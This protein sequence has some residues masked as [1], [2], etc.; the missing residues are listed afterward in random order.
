MIQ[1][2]SFNSN[3][4]IKAPSL[5]FS[6]RPFW[7]Q[8][9]LAH[10]WIVIIVLSRNRLHLTSLVSTHHLLTTHVTHWLLHHLLMLLHLLNHIIIWRAL[11]ILK[12]LVSICNIIIIWILG[13]S[14]INTRMLVALHMRLVMLLVRLEMRV[15]ILSW[16]TLSIALCR[17]LR[18]ILVAL[19]SLWRVKVIWVHLLLIVVVLLLL[20]HKLRR[21]RKLLLLTRLIVWIL[22]VLHHLCLL[23]RH[24][25]GVLLLQMLLMWLH[26]INLFVILILLI[27]RFNIDLILC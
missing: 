11:I 17:H 10:I 25:L 9:I 16:M 19:Q 5:L 8:P 21:K 20:P 23:L 3:I 4:Q 27:L 1:L 18:L 13:L 6:I 2:W 24:L 26:L 15:H 22:L 12:T 7:I 14:L